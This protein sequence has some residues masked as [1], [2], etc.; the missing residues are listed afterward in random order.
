MM[1]QRER[2]AAWLS[3]VITMP[4]VCV[5]FEHHSEATETKIGRILKNCWNRKKLK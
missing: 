3:Q 5:I 2:G 4:G 1:G